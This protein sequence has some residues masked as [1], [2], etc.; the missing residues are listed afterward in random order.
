MIGIAG[1]AYLGSVLANDVESAAASPDGNSVALL[2]GGALHILRNGSASLIAETAEAPLAWSP[3][4]TTVATGSRLIRISDG[5]SVNL[6][7]LN[8]PAV[9]LAA[10]NDHAVAA[11]AG[12]VWLLNAGSARLLASAEEAAAVSIH[13]NELYFADR[14]RGE[15]WLLRDYTNGG[16]PVLVAKIDGA[17]GVDVARDRILIAAGQKV[18]ALRAAT[19]EP[20][21]ELDVDF[22]ASGLSRLNASTWLLNAGQQGPLQVLSLDG[23]PAVYFVPRGEEAHQ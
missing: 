9:A 23:D 22:T 16:A 1:S 3:D 15:V 7:A 12:G 17:A 6:P 11:A 14:A 8:G 2:K 5:S 13:G 18:I 20:L 4:S 10:A 19:F 21:F